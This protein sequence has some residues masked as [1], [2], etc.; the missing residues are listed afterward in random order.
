MEYMEKMIDYI[1]QLQNLMYMS[2]VEK[3]EFLT[4]Q[5]RIV[6]HYIEKYEEGEEEE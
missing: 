5:N 2:F 1:H 4:I 3:D 6:N